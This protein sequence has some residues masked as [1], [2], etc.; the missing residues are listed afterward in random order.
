MDHDR[1]FAFVGSGGGVP[2]KDMIRHR[3]KYAIVHPHYTVI[4]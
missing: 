4:F 3:A 2:K 1:A